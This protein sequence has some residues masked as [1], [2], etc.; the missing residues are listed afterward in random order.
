MT[1]THQPVISTRL[2]YIVLLF[3]TLANLLLFQLQNNGKFLVQEK[4]LVFDNAVYLHSP[5]VPPEPFHATV[6][7]YAHQN[8]THGSWIG[9]Q[10]IPPPSS[11]SG[12]YSSRL[13]SVFEM[14]QY[15]SQTTSYRSMVFVGDSNARQSYAT[16][17]AILNATTNHH[18]INNLDAWDLD[19]P[20]VIDRNRRNITELCPR[21]LTLCRTL[22]N[23]RNSSDAAVANI[24]DIDYLMLTCPENNL[25]LRRL[26]NDYNII[27]IH[28]G[29]WHLMT[30][31][32]MKSV[33]GFRK[34]ILK[35][36]SLLLERQQQQKSSSQH[37]AATTTTRIIW[38]TMG[39]VGHNKPSWK[40]AM[41]V[42]AKM[43][44]FIETISQNQQGN[45]TTNA[46]ILHHSFTILDWGAVVEPRSW[47]D[48]DRIV[49]DT[50]PHYGLEARLVLVQMLM[51]HLLLLEHGTIQS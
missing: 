35:L 10:W 49:G 32:K 12:R 44:R 26:V 4:A 6:V 51:N 36:E 31:C 50:N 23:N 22:R 38:V 39:T 47:P 14:Q 28:L 15:F 8:N 33:R 19:D 17:Y 29:A 45:T 34:L 30:Y 46:A 43:R 18:N 48:Q 2:Q 25:S 24:H 13:Y 41:E 11:Y 42:N 37:P 16:L 7:A 3:L 1:T 21:N 27:V 20:D 5:S 9:N 40:R